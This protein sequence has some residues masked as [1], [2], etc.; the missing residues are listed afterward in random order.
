MAKTLAQGRK[1]GSGR[2]PGKAKTLLEG[3]KPGSGRKKRQA[4]D[5]MG[6][7]SLSGYGSFKGLNKSGVLKKKEEQAMMANMGYVRQ[8]V[9]PV[10]TPTL[11]NALISPAQY[12][13]NERAPNLIRHHELDVLDAFEKLRKSPPPQQVPQL[14]AHPVPYIVRPNLPWPID[15]QSLQRPILS[16]VPTSATVNVAD[17][18][19]QNGN[20]DHIVP[21]SNT[22]Q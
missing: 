1:P 3:R 21:T 15:S 4:I 18:S 16:P 19:V 10:I 11:P 14:Q 2:K 8:M 17:I 6:A 9:T 22:T 7:A 13:T 5:A 12:I 20:N